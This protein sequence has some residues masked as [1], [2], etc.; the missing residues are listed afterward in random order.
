[1]SVADKIPGFGPKREIFTVPGGVVVKVTAPAF[2]GTPSVGVYLTS[3]QY[4]RYKKWRAGAMIQ[5]ALP[6]LS[7]DDREALMSGLSGDAWD[8]MCAKFEKMEPSHD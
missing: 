2:M 4:K 6:E 8:A 5:H 7:R 1:M 3:D